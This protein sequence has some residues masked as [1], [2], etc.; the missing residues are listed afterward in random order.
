MEPPSPKLSRESFQTK[1]RISAVVA[2][3]PNPDIRVPDVI[4]EVVRKPVQIAAPEA[5]SIKMEVLWIR[6]DLVDPDL[7]LSE[8]IVTELPR[9]AI[10]LP[11]NFVQVPL[12]TPMKPNLHVG[13][14][15]RQA[16]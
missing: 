10:V 7:K 12:N 6:A 13:E 14:A 2:Q 4:K 3:H 11:Q 1:Y 9:N 16:R 15:P 5:A 8:E